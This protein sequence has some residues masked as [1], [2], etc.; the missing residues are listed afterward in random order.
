MP[1]VD[2]LK[3]SKSNELPRILT[4]DFLRPLNMEGEAIPNAFAMGDAADVKG[5]EL[6]T[7]AELACQKGLYLAKVF[8]SSL[9]DP[10]EYQQRALVAYTGQHDGVI[11]GKRD[12]SG[13]GTWLA[14]RSKNLGWSR[15]WRNKILTTMDWSLDHVLGKEIALA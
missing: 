1:L 9:Q 4:D 8:N 5:G 11:A 13:P 15:S 10:F 3:V 12:W 14:W 2:V 7:T 6:P